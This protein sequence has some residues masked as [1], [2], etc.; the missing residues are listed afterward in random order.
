ML[1]RMVA[2]SP[3]RLVAVANRPAACA[4]QNSPF[5]YFALLAVTTLADNVAANV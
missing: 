2:Q 3:R 4:P 5:A 1:L